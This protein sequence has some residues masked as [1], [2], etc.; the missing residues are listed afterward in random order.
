MEQK[1]KA[2]IIEKLVS[3]FTPYVDGVL[4]EGSSAWIGFRK[5]HD[6]DL[7]FLVPNFDFLRIMISSRIPIREVAR[8]LE[9]FMA[10][11]F[12]FIISLNLEMFSL[13]IFP[14]GEEISLR[15]TKSKLFERICRLRLEKIKRTRSIF[16][17]RLYPTLPIDFQRNFSGEKIQ[18]FRQCFSS[19]QNQ[20]IETTIVI[21]DKR[22]RFYPG[23]I[24][25]RY[26]SFPKILYEKNSFCQKNL[27]KLKFN[28][29]KRLMMEER[30]NLHFHTPSFVLCLSRYERIPK[31]LIEQLEEEGRQIRSQI[32]G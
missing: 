26:L 1:R 32:K 3:I 25:D 8:V 11:S 14:E 31:E 13:K 10:R 21:I 15:F 2:K 18:Y 19:G 29:I 27:K 9:D 17:Y 20:L 12:S 7:E 5:G 6:V 4:M 22:G 30:E 24:I 16:Q 23:G 28:I